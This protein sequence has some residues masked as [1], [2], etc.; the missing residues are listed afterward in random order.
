MPRSVLTDPSPTL[1][2]VTDLLEYRLDGPVAVLTFDDGKANAYTHEALDAIGA[3]LDRA[4]DEATAV[5]LVGRPGRF[6]AGFDLSVMTSGLEP[7]RALVAAGAR[8]MLR[9]FTYPMPV[10][11]ACTGHALAAGALVLLSCDRRIGAEGDYKLGLNEVAI[12]MGLP[13][14][15]VE[16]ARYRMPSSAFDSVVLGRTFDPAG[17]VGAGFLDRAVAADDVVAAATAEAHDL[18]A[19]STG[20][21]AHTKRLARQALADEILGGLEADMAGTGGPV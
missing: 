18:A 5:L 12:G 8:L 15:A 14:F 20:A 13:H 11:A 6:S 19:L 16:L 17:A 21:V 9:L 3:G 10:V 1:R 2:E 7:M 4:S